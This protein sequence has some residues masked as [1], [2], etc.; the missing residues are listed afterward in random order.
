M[1]SAVMRTRMVVSAEGFV[2][3]TSWIAR[4]DTFA[5]G[6]F[7]RLRED[8]SLESSLGTC[9]WEGIWDAMRR[10][11]LLIPPRQ[12]RGNFVSAVRADPRR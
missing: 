1:I 4:L 10:L 9:Q 8:F 7:G 2:A 6:V 12:T 5:V 3:R 11:V